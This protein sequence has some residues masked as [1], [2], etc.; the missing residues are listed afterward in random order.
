MQLQR[1][2]VTQSAAGLLLAALAKGE[3]GDAAVFQQQLSESVEAVTPRRQSPQ[4]RREQIESDAPPPRPKDA[5]ARRE[6]TDRPPDATE[7]PVRG[8]RPNRAKPVSSHKAEPPTPD[9]G[10]PIRAA[11][12]PTPPEAS[13]PAVPAAAA[14][15][16]QQSSGPVQAAAQAAPAAPPSEQG[17][18]KA[19]QTLIKAL[20][21]QATPQ[22]VVPT[23]VPEQ[24]QT[25]G[26][27]DTQALQALAPQRPL[28]LESPPEAPATEAVHP[29]TMQAAFQVLQD[30]AVEQ[31]QTASRTRR[32]RAAGQETPDAGIV[33]TQRRS[34]PDASA[35]AAEKQVN[36]QRGADV[37]SALTTVP[38]TPAVRAQVVTVTVTQVQPGSQLSGNESADA[39]STRIPALAES[40]RPVPGAAARTPGSQSGANQAEQVERIARVIRASLSRGG[41]RVSL[42]LD[43]PDLG[44]L[45]V[46]MQLRGSDLFARFE[47]QTDAARAFLEQNLGQLR[48]S[49]ASSGLRLVEA[50]VEHRPPGDGA[51]G[52][53]TSGPGTFLG[54]AAGNRQQGQQ[55]S[56]S[57]ATPQNPDSDRPTWADVPVQDQK[58]NIVA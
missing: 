32:I 49:L 23:Q 31:G 24:E 9:D 48:E 56:H 6:E 55:A 12:D 25:D 47:A 8:R 5:S 52:G 36:M 37:Q 22:L 7:V 11:D 16:Q 39:G 1:T 38:Q 54:D 30:P 3:R 35:T 44:H 42:Q 4:D 20:A 28:R 26:I 43:P 53:Q 34:V 17:R 58:L 13:E 46:Q 10:A 27:A 21:A 45:R 57:N 29:A 41:S 15:A 40:A 50:A 33:R 51:A 18:S 19:A 14:D 2:N